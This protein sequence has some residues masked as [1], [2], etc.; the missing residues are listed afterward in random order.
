M[1]MLAQSMGMEDQSPRPREQEAG[2]DLL[3]F[4]T[5]V[6]TIT[7]ESELPSPAQSWAQV[8]NVRRRP[9]RH[10][11][12]PAFYPPPAQYGHYYPQQVYYNHW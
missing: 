3:D 7:M 10:R 4:D 2:E 11:Q 12:A 5:D 1:T 8:R 9:V 6:I